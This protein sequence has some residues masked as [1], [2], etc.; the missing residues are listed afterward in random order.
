MKKM[1]VNKTFFITFVF[2]IA[3]FLIFNSSKGFAFKSVAYEKSYQNEINEI[4]NKIDK[5][6]NLKKGYEAEAIKHNNIAQRLQFQNGE[7]QTAKK[8]WK[9]ADENS[10]I[11]LRIQKEIDA[12]KIKKEKI[13]KEHH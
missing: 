10:R 12:L 1:S 7:L 4:D 3:I 11:S 6:E 13:L 5:L 8:H 2:F 9:I